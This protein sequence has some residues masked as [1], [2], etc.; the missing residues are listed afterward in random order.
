MRPESLDLIKDLRP[1]W[2][3]RGTPSWR[4]A[5]M[6]SPPWSV[7]KS[8][9]S[10]QLPLNLLSALRRKI[11]TQIATDAICVAIHIARAMY[12]AM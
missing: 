4:T 10:R 1:H 3:V 11:A 12:G 5:T 8:W 6:E 7:I 9:I 2:P